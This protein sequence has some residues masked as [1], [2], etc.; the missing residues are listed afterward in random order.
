MEE[1]GGQNFRVLHDRYISKTSKLR[2]GL[3][4]TGG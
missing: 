1:V 2:L 4:L 3:L